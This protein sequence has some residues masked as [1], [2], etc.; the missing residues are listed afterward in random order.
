MVPAQK[1]NI[2]Q[3]NKIK[4]PKKTPHTY[5]HLIFD[6]GGKNMQ[7]RKDNLFNKWFWENKTATYKIMKSE[8]FVTL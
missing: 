2:A 8:H 5:G 3:W 7:W 4:S 6:K 1:K